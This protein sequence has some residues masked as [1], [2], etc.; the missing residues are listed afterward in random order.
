MRYI[1]HCAIEFFSILCAGAA[2]KHE[3]SPQTLSIHS[4]ASF[5]V[6][7][8]ALSTAPSASG[9]KGSTDAQFAR[10][11]HAPPAQ[12]EL[13]PWNALL[14]AGRTN[15]HTVPVPELTVFCHGRSCSHPGFS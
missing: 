4:N 8:L 15:D 5:Q 14:L 1:Y 10:R 6:A 12:K 7:R 11:S 3:F 13:D 2:A 9:G